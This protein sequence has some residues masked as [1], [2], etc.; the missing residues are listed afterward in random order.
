MNPAFN[1]RCHRASL[2]WSAKSWE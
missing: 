1:F 2:Y